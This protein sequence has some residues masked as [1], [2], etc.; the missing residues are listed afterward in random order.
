MLHCEQER[1]AQYHGFEIL[2]VRDPRL[3]MFHVIKVSDYSKVT[4]L[5]D[6]GNV[7]FCNDLLLLYYSFVPAGLNLLLLVVL[8]V[9]DVGDLFDAR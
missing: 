4:I 1:E 8:A 2:I 9:R 5:V 7:Y 6:N 3:A